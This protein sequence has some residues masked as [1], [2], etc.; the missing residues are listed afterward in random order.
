MS[1]PSVSGATRLA[2]VIG[3]P[4]R[5][6]LSPAIHN[7][8]YDACDLDWV[9][10]ALEVA[11]G[12]AAEALAGM[13]A[14]GIAG[15]SVTMPHKDDVYA[16]VDERSPAAATMR[17][18]NCV[19]LL[20]GRLV[21]HNT[22]G[23]GFVDSLRLDAGIDPAGLRVAVVGAGGAARSVVEALARAGASDIAIVNRTPSRAAE[24]AALGAGRGR[25]G[26]LDDVCAAQLV[27]NA[28]SVG[29]GTDELSID[30]D[31]IQRGQVVADLVYHPLETALLRAAAERGARTVDGLGMLVHQAARQFTLWTGVEAPVA[32]MRRAAEAELVRRRT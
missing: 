14:L 5:H 20:D 31:L 27:I 22:D 11:P 13:R 30:R 4:V 17:A 25:V 3:S 15:L 23:D 18:V 1:R 24:A 32:D 29:L 7:A 9:Y 16:L 28:T 12:R 19:Q 8:A 26:D 2:A 21:G 6:S 10:V